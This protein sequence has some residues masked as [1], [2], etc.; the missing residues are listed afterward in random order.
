MFDERNNT[1]NIIVDPNRMG[2]G[3]PLID[4]DERGRLYSISSWNGLSGLEQWGFKQ[5]EGNETVET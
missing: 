4:E 3:S 5:P 2:I 1:V